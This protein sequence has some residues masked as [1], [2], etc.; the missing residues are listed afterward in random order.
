[1]LMVQFSDDNWHTRTYDAATLLAIGEAQWGY[2]KGRVSYS[3]LFYAIHEEQGF[4]RNRHTWE[5]PLWMAWLKGMFPDSTAWFA[6]K[7]LSGAPVADDEI[8]MSVI[9]ARKKDAMKFALDHPSKSFIFGHYQ[10]D[11]MEAFEEALP[12]ATHTDTIWSLK[13]NSGLANVLPDYTF[14]APDDRKTIP[15]LQ[16]GTGCPHNCAFCTVEGGYHPHPGNAVYNQIESFKA[17]E[18]KLCYI[19]D[20]TFSRHSLPS[21]KMAAEVIRKYNPAF[22][23]FIVQTTVP[24]VLRN[25]RAFEDSTIKYVEAGVEL[26]SDEH[27]KEWRKPTSELCNNQLAMV[28]AKSS[29]ELI[30]N[31]MTGVPGVDYTKTY[32]YCEEHMDVC[33]TFNHYNYANYTS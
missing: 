25:W 15:R 14:L 4:V 9:E 32:K 26:M 3:D 16:L 17:L 21:L 33:H 6:P 11:T 31:I 13:A 1:M 18:F 2:D 27:L 29:L 19:D 24:V 30:P 7:W 23:G 22:E 10:Q 28:A 8:A 20:K 5:P 12:W